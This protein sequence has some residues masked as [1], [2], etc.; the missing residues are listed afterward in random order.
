MKVKLF[1]LF[2]LIIGCTD[3]NDPDDNFDSTLPN[4]EL[5]TKSFKLI[6][7]GGGFGESESVRI[8]FSGSIANNTD[9]VFKTYRQNIL[10]TAQNGNEITG[11]FTLPILRWLC[12]FDTLIG[13][14]RSD[15]FQ[16]GF[17]DSVVSWKII[18]QG[19]I[20]VYGIGNECD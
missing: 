2:A 12:P 4:I 19:L 18:E 9:N 13:G 5:D 7:T 15:T 16:P 14:G 20:A 6:V 8:N 11:Q 17:I 3:N 10:F 1:I